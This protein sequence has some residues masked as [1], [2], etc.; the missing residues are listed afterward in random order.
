MNCIVVDDDEMSRTSLE[1]LCEHIDDLTVTAVFSSGLQAVN[2]LKT[3]DVDLVFLDIEMPDLSGMDLVKSIDDLPQIIFTTGHKEYAVEAFE[4]QVTDFIPK[5]VELPRL[6]KAVNRAR[7]LNDNVRHQDQNDLFVRV[8]GRFVRIELEQVL[9]IESLGDYVTFVLEDGKRFIV[10]ST[11]KN[12]ASKITNEKFLKIHRSYV[13]NL[14]KVVDIEETNL[15]IKDKVIPISR[16]HK[17][18]LMN[19]IKTL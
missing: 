19:R 15:V 4:H 14:S 13:V 16:A 6:L 12:I 17:P 2:W 9:Y 8:D 10:H 1:M 11:V 7:E 3:N 5:P 18:I